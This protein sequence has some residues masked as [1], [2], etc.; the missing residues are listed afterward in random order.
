MTKEDLYNNKARS[1]CVSS[2]L[3]APVHSIFMLSQQ[4]TPVCNSI[5]F[6][7]IIV[8]QISFTQALVSSVSLSLLLSVPK[9]CFPR[10]FVDLLLLIVILLDSFCYPEA[11][12]FITN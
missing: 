11:L 7:P 2:L 6:R 12:L 5:R 8:F 10:K 9:V 1:G 3:S 4:V